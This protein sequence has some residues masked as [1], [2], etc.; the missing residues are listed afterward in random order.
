MLSYCLKCRKN[1][2]IKKPNAVNTKNGR[3]ILLPKC[4]VYGSRKWIFIKEQET[5]GLLNSLGRKTPAIRI[6]LVGLLLF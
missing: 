6:P 4:A 1:T 2:E 5:S 3:I